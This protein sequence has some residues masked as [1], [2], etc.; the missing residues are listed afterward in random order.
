MRTAHTKSPSSNLMI[1]LWE[2]PAFLYFK[3]CAISLCN[4]H[5]LIWYIAKIFYFL[6]NLQIRHRGQIQNSMWLKRTDSFYCQFLSTE[7]PTLEQ[8]LRSHSLLSRPELSRPLM[9]ILHMWKLLLGESSSQSQRQWAIHSCL[10]KTWVS[11]LPPHLP[12]LSYC[13]EDYRKS[14]GQG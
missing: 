3:L 6:L 14:I 9:R 10:T 2:S 5:E 11:L 13:S 7:F 1:R 12:D 4:H 8:T